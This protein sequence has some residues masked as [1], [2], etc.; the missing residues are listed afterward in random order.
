[1]KEKNLKTEQTEQITDMV[2]TASLVP[3]IHPRCGTT[4]QMCH[5][6]VDTTSDTSS[7]A[8]VI[9]GRPVKINS[10]L[11]MHLSIEGAQLCCSLDLQR[12][13]KS[14]QGAS[15]SDARVDAW[16]NFRPSLC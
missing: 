6:S 15:V 13:P 10:H 3:A 16:I 9:S 7:C 12:S 8:H 14:R 11:Q 1:M 5:V 2:C 4:R